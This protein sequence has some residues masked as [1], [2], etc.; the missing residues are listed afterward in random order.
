M[1]SMCIITICSIKDILSIKYVYE[2]YDEVILNTKK[3]K[4]SGALRYAIKYSF[5]AVKKSGLL[6]I[7]D[8]PHKSY[9]F[10]KRKIEFWQVKLEVFKD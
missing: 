4:Y 8:E 10:S 9:V 3:L 7:V 2:K 1:I 5:W 6:K